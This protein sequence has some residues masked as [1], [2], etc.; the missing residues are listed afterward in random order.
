MTTL[1]TLGSVLRASVDTSGIITLGSSVTVSWLIGADDKWHDPVAKASVRQRDTDGM[2]VIETAMRIPS[3]DAVHRVWAAR[4]SAGVDAAVVEIANESAVPVALA[5]VVDAVRT[6]EYAGTS[7]KVGGV[8]TLSFARA[9]MRFAVGSPAEVRAAITGGSATASWPVPGDSPRRR[10]RSTGETSA[11]FV[12]PLTHR[13]A[14][15]F[16]VGLGDGVEPA[17]SYAGMDAVVRGWA[18]HLSGGV[19]VELGDP[20]VEQVFA[21]RRVSALLADPSGE[22]VEQLCS[23]GLI[24]DA[25]GM[26]RRLMYLGAS[27]ADRVV[28]AGA[29]WRMHRRPVDSEGLDALAAG[30]ARRRSKAG[31]RAAGAAADVLDAVGQHHAASRVRADLDQP[32]CDV[33]SAGGSQDGTAGGALARS[34]VTSTDRDSGRPT[35]DI[36]VVPDASLLVPGRDIAV[37]HWP[38]AFG[39]FGFAIR[40]H[41]QFPALLW[42]LEPHPGEPSVTIRSSVAAPDWSSTALSGETL[43]R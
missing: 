27:P 42:T 5:V 19:R 6:I 12:L 4:S 28:A 10:G 15:R 41:G 43:L 23:W 24:D 18:A 2:P 14:S 25:V 8:P 35:G 39:K 9:P 31:W 17:D 40:W 30:V 37:Y 13:T 34:V 1:G 21:R 11:G 36:D 7:V 33:L 3:G 16:V 32:L 26:V 20:L 38:T 29:C 22:A